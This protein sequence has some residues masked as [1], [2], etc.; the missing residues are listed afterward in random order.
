MNSDNITGN[1][2]KFEYLIAQTTCLIPFTIYKWFPFRVSNWRI[3]VRV[4]V[5]NAT[6]NNISVGIGQFDSGENHRPVASHWQ[7]LS[8]NVVSNSPRYEWG[9]ELTTLAVQI[10]NCID[11]CRSNLPY[12]HDHDGLVSNW[13]GVYKLQFTDY[14]IWFMDE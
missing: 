9:F 3:V 2:Y 4:M 8:H 11:S 12:D 1:C 14:I 6:F 5:F 10:G 13:K 7:T